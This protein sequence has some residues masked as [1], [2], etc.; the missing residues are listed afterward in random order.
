MRRD[1][2]LHNVKQIGSESVSPTRHVYS[3][4]PS[5]PI[6]TMCSQILQDD[7]SLWNELNISKDFHL[8]PVND[9]KLREGIFVDMSPSTTMYMDPPNQGM[10]H[11]SSAGTDYAFGFQYDEA[12]YLS[13]KDDMK[14]LEFLFACPTVLPCFEVFFWILCIDK[15]FQLFYTELLTQ[16][17][18]M[19][20][21][22]DSCIRASTFPEK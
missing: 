10:S 9:N 17:K 20:A 8:P 1:N 22:K 12:E 21:G 7:T 14:A 18:I 3:F 6:I 15:S 19:N 4:C 13:S 16:C 2:G 5:N 11:R